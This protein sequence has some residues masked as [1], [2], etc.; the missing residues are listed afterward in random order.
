M[1]T[2]KWAFASKT[3]QKCNVRV[4]FL[5]KIRRNKCNLDAVTKSFSESF[6][7]V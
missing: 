4:F 2:I 7:N 5:I 1:L 3:D 6:I